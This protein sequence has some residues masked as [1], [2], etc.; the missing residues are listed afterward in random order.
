MKPGITVDKLFPEKSDPLAPVQIN[1]HKTSL[2]YID[3]A[4]AAIRERGD[5]PFIRAR[6]S[7]GFADNAP[8]E[9]RTPTWS[10]LI[11]LEEPAGY[12]SPTAQSCP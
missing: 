7:M 10:C 4:Q 1:A 3:E 8:C 9:V 6:L 5:V 11:L 2:P 12:S